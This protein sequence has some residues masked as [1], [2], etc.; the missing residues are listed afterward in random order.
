MRESFG[1]NVSGPEYPMV[2]RIKNL[3]IKNILLKIDSDI[4]SA[5]VK[6]HLLNLIKW[7]KSQ[8]KYK[9]IKVKIDVDPV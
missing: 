9:S 5:K 6:K 3:Y 2:S 8:S 7:L 4:S 1:T